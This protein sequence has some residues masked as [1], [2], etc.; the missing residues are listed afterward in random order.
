MASLDYPRR[1]T[2]GAAAA[3]RPGLF[4]R[5]VATLRDWRDEAQTRDALLN[6]SDRELDDIGLTRYDIDRAARGSIRR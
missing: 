5:I 3:H 1:V 2:F 6:L 4:A